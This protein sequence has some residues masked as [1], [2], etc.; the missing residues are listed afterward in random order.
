M[1]SNRWIITLTL[2]LG[3]TLALAFFAISGQAALTVRGLSAPADPVTDPVRLPDDIQI[4]T[5]TLNI[6][7]YI[8]GPS[9]IIVRDDA[10]SWHHL[11]WAAPGRLDGA[12]EPTYLNG[13]AWYPTWPDIPDPGNYFCDCD[14]STYVGVPALAMQA[15]IASLE[16]V[17]AREIVTIIQ[18]PEAGNDYTL[19]LE[20]NDN[21]YGGAE[22][23]EINIVY[24]SYDYVHLYPPAQAGSGETGSTVTY[25][26][27]L[28]NQT[29]ISDTFS[30]ALGSPA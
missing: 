8:D 19:I 3:L 7:A 17:Q 21:S 23:Y 13:V 29:G 22:W 2:V 16:I 14:S 20:F 9:H 1:K 24:I 26:V 10:V 30:L 5:A 28:A 27:Q 11:D 18:Q 12:N 6:S 25:T 15:Q 4:I